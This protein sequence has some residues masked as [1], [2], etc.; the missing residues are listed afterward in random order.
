VLGNYAEFFVT[1]NIM[2]HIAPSN[3]S[4]VTTVHRGSQA[5]IYC[6]DQVSLQHTVA[7]V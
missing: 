1:A 7:A 3:L 2:S 6:D 5:Y 4:F